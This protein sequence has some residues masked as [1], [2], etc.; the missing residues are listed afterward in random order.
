M[1]RIVEVVRWPWWTV[2]A[3]W[4]QWRAKAGLAAWAKSTAEVEEIQRAMRLRRE[5]RHPAEWVEDETWDA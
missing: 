3:A 4:R 5:A 2:R 1:N